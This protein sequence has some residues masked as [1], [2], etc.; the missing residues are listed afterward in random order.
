MTPFTEAA[1]LYTK[2]IITFPFGCA[3]AGCP[4][5]CRAAPSAGTSSATPVGQSV[6]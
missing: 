4:A 1:I 3:R 6:C 5:A 2:G